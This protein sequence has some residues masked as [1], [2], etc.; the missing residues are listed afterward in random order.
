MP[1]QTKHNQTD[2]DECRAKGRA[3]HIFNINDAE[4][5][6]TQYRG[7][8][9]MDTLPYSKPKAQLTEIEREKQEYVDDYVKFY[10]GNAENE[11]NN[12]KYDDVPRPGK[13]HEPRKDNNVSERE[14]QEMSYVDDYKKF[15]G[16]DD[17]RYDP[18]GK[19]K[20]LT[21]S[22]VPKP[23]FIEKIHHDSK[24]QDDKNY[25]SDKE[26]EEKALVSDYCKFHGMNDEMYDTKQGMKKITAD[27][28]KLSMNQSKN[29]NT[30]MP[31][32]KRNVP[33]NYVQLQ[34]GYNNPYAQ[35]VLIEILKKR[36]HKI[37]QK[38]RFL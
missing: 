32:L 25:V 23:A 34:D 2:Y 38:I 5:V 11:N 13:N 21:Y 17:E 1:K 8:K 16:M 28:V 6:P 24:F 27:Q 7:K 20:N 29:N 10:G 35:K 33:M 15:Y 18:R 9:Q 26:K 22:Q 31:N 19:G 36:H 14:K 37:S 30:S 12:L 4:P 3:D